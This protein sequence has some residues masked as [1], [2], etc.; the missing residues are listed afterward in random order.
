MG[1]ILHEHIKDFKS[2]RRQDAEAWMRIVAEEYVMDRLSTVV[3]RIMFK[4]HNQE[5]LSKETIKK[6]VTKH[7]M[8]SDEAI[9]S[10]I[11]TVTILGIKI[12][13]REGKIL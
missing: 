1:I 13:E 10:Y 11:D 5:G 2:T 9:K 12:L 7:P 4:Y 8:L 6:V 3:G